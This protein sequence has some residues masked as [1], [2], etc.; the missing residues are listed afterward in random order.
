MLCVPPDDINVVT[1]TKSEKQNQ[2]RSPTLETD[3][4]S[5]A[6]G[7]DLFRKLEKVGSI[8]L[9]ANPTLQTRYLLD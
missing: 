1:V 2:F 3:V 9:V 4:A 5:D 6:L 7:S 8:N